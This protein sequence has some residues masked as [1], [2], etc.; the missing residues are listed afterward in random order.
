MTYQITNTWC[1]MSFNL[2][3][4]KIQR[5]IRRPY[6]EI[7]VFCIKRTKIVPKYLFLHSIIR[8]SE[9]RDIF[10]EDYTKEEILDII[11]IRN[12]RT[13]YFNPLNDELAVTFKKRF[14]KEYHKTI[15]LADKFING[16]FDLLGRKIIFENW[17]KIGKEKWPLLPSYKI[18]YYGKEILDDIKIVWEI[19]RMQ[20]LPIIGKAYFLTKNEKYSKKALWYIS[21]WIEQNPYLKGVNWMEGIEAA[22]RMY[23]WIFTYHF[24]LSSPNLTPE[25]SLQILKSIYQHGKFIY[26]F[27]SDKWSINNNHILAELSAL[28]LI[29][30]V[31]PQFKDSKKWLKFSVKKL[32]KEINK[33][34]FEEGVIWEHSSGY[35]KFVTELILYPI[36]L[37]QKNG[38][39]IPKSTTEKAER[40]VEFLN[41]ISMKGGK[42]PLVGDEDQ[43]F[44]L[45]FGNWEYDNILEVSSAGSVLFKREDF[46]K[47]KSELVFWLFDGKI[48]EENRDSFG[49]P[50]FRIFDKSGYAVF[51][52]KNDYFLF[53]TSSQDKRYL[54]APHRHL[55]MLSFIYSKN[56]KYFI[57]DPGTYTYFGNYEMRNKFR[58]ISMHNTLRI[59]GREPSDLSGLFEIY[60]R[61]K[62]KIVKW[63]KFGDEDTKYVWAIHD[64]YKP[65]IHNRIII[66][67]GKNFI[68]YDMVKGNGKKH[69]FE[70]YIHLHPSV[71]I[72]HSSGNHVILTKSAESIIIY[73]ENGIKI[74]NSL[75]SEKYG[76]FIYSK[77]LKV[78]KIA[79]NYENIFVISDY[80]PAETIKLSDIKNFVK[81]II[82]G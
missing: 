54:H 10:C 79:N 46:M 38:Y 2:W 11:K 13:F 71:E 52:S 21:S 56:E 31:F 8:E 25:I 6:R 59:D 47:I 44:V 36:I 70:S 68:I 72:V 34:V 51:K 45:K 43:G 76:T 75:F 60:P 53:I 3:V 14:N 74:T 67:L 27:L 20:F 81:K 82:N 64:G 32:E 65:L 29:S 19:N 24:I 50:I 22:I 77:A 66:H 63:G 9:K 55:D 12:H 42:I 28:I 39:S 17:H 18:G 41:I 5:M 57:V 80:S 33:Q 30:L 37:L 16:Y 1:K 73:S 35:Q 49:Y 58:S 62:T 78:E 48:M 69:K 15:E 26:E 40:M 23:A 4:P 61:P 7:L